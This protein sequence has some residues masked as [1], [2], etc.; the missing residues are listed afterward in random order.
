MFARPSVTTVLYEF[1]LVSLMLQWMHLNCATID[2]CIECLSITIGPPK[3]VGGP[4]NDAYD[5][6]VASIIVNSNANNSKYQQRSY[7]AHSISYLIYN[8]S[9]FLQNPAQIGLNPGPSKNDYDFCGDWLNAPINNLNG[10]ALNIV[11]GFYH[12]EWKCDYAHNLY[13]NKS[14]AYALSTNGGL[15]FTKP[16]YPNNQIISPPN[17]TTQ[18][19]TGEGDHQIAVINS[20]TLYLYFMEFDGY[21]DTTTTGL[22]RSHQNGLPGT[23]YK[24]LNG[25]FK[26]PG[27]GGDSSLIANITGTCVRY[28]AEYDDFIAMGSFMADNEIGYGPRLSFSKNGIDSWIP[29]KE[30]LIFVDENSW[31]FNGNEFLAYVSL[32]STNIVFNEKRNIYD[33]LFNNSYWLYYTY[34][35]PNNNANNKYLTQRSLNIVQNPNVIPVNVPQVL[36]ALS[37]YYSSGKD[38]SWITTA[39]IPISDKYEIVNEV[40]GMIMTQPINALSVRV[41]DCYIQ[42]PSSDHMIALQNECESAHGNILRTLGWLYSKQMDNEYLNTKT[43]YRCFDSSKSDHFVSFDQNCDNKGTEQ[44]LLGYIITPK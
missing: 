5:T 21:N 38:D 43:L 23:W 8:N 25:E 6:S 35:P 18:H 11:H 19:T 39:L 14:I 13:T 36:I 22:A 3:Q 1:I 16:N 32:V 42:H 29:M 40:Y 20:S 12:E 24:Y 17:S 9:E 10:D 4:P 31:V 26:S 37:Y 27:L 7:N 2:N 28:R 30:P 44:V 34:I 41:Y 15:S 33:F